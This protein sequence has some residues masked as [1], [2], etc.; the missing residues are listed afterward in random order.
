MTAPNAHPISETAR[1]Q[2]RV[3]ELE[4]ERD[5]WRRRCE[6][7]L[8]LGNKDPKKVVAAVVARVQT[9]A[10]VLGLYEE[11]L[12]LAVVASDLHASAELAEKSLE[13]MEGRQ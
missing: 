5:R 13:Q 7:M 9:C 10:A 11:P 4:M 2:A 1:L 8:G 6:A 12:S 3:N